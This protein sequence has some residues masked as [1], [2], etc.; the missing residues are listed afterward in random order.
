[1]IKYTSV[2]HYIA[3][4]ITAL[5]YMAHWILVPCGMIIFLFYEVDEDY[6]I[7][8]QAFI[9]IREFM[10]AYFITCAGL[11]IWRLIR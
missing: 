10:V 11:I 3:G 9:D 2:A 5:S 1:M 6:H 4:S 8:D 7:S